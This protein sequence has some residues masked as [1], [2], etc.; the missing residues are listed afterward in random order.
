M[1]IQWFGHSA[2][3]IETENGVRILTDP[4][5][6]GAYGGAL[7]YDPIEMEADIVTVSHEQHEDH[8]HTRTVRGDPLIAKGPGLDTVKGVEI[9]RVH[10]FH[11]ESEGKERG[12]NYV[13]CLKADGMR[14]CHMGDLGHVLTDSQ[15]QEIGQPDVMLIPVG[16]TFTVGPQ[17]ASRVAEQLKPR[18]LIPMHYKTPKCGFPIEEVDAFLEGKSKVKKMKG[19]TV[20]LRQAS[21]PDPTEIVVLDPAL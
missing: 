21:L 17:E 18:V 3:L 19:S 9:R 16:G 15:V 1:K 10:T 5:E 2:F 14:V 11:D 8:N 12:E 7:G 6:S 13:F 4:Y 20:E